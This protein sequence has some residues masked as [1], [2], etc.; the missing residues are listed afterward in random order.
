MPRWWYFA[1]YFLCLWKLMLPNLSSIQKCSSDITKKK[2]QRQLMV[3]PHKQSLWRNL[4][5]EKNISHSFSQSSNKNTCSSVKCVVNMWLTNVFIEFHYECYYKSKNKP[6]RSDRQC[7]SDNFV[8]KYTLFFI[9]TWGS[10][11]GSRHSKK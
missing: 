9:D 7:Q 5:M 4:Y 2:F 8:N 1:R 3:L 11:T 6:F 10:F